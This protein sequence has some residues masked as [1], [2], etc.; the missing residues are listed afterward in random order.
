MRRLKKDVAEGDFH[1][2]LDYSSEENPES[3]NG[4]PIK[5]TLEQKREVSITFVVEYSYWTIFLCS[6]FT[7]IYIEIL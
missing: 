7:K 2:N 3:E 4:S 6:L 1:S 5:S